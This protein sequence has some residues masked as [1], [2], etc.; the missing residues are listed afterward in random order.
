MLV[1]RAVGH[2]KKKAKKFLAGV[3]CIG[4]LAAAADLYAHHLSATS[5][6]TSNETIHTVTVS[7]QQ[8]SNMQ[9][10]NITSEI[11]S[12]P[13]KTYYRNRVVIVTFHDIAPTVYSPYV[14][15]PLQ[16]TEDLVAIKARFHVLTN[17]EFINFLDHEGTIPPNSVLLTFDDGYRDM[18]TY[19]LP[20]LLS[21][22]LQGTFFEIVGTADK[23][24]TEYLSWNQIK[25]MAHDGM[26]IES[27]TYDS[28]Y[29]VRSSNGEMEPVFDTRI[30]AN[31][32]RETLSHYDT[33]VY[34]DFSRARKELEV[35]TGDAVTQF[36][37][38]FGW[39]TTESTYLAERAGYGYIY[40]TTNGYVAA[41]TDHFEIPRI[42]I[43]KPGISPATAL[44]LIIRF[45]NIQENLG[46]GGLHHHH[47]H[48][49]EVNIVAETNGHKPG[50]TKLGTQ[51]T[52]ISSMVHTSGTTKSGAQSFAKSSTKK[53]TTNSATGSAT[54]GSATSRVSGTAGTSGATGTA[55]PSG[56]SKSGSQSGIQSTQTKSQKGFTNKT[57][58]VNHV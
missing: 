30:V 57:T 41:N 26:V 58:I 52:G 37:W 32:K 1:E 13:A 21:L 5:P 2:M 42:D 50:S 46:G 29:Q 14:I 27:H 39:G 56:T 8:S 51:K 48:V 18:Y 19:A 3:M 16:F 11:S 38:P 35:N 17:H 54:K 49:T 28:H 7:R 9:L 20:V 33:R 36:A 6:M 53:L 44:K 47:H 25:T 43:G 31:G 10:S 12:I 15:T 45:A 34:N 55:G 23:Q 40:T 22:H 4:M 24:E